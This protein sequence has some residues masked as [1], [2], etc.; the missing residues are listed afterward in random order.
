[1]SIKRKRELDQEVPDDDWLPPRK[2]P[3]QNLLCR[4]IQRE[5]YPAR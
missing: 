5:T 1:M 2:I 3:P 4:L